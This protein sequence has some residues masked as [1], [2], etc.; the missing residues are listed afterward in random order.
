MSCC[1]DGDHQQRL[2]F[3]ASSTSRLPGAPVRLELHVSDLGRLWHVQ[4]FK[5]DPQRHVQVT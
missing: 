4:G 1:A 2:D 5:V 3:L